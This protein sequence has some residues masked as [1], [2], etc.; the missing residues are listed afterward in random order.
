[1][2]WAKRS[3]DLQEGVLAVVHGTPQNGSMMAR[4]SLHTDTSIHMA[5]H[6]SLARLI[7]PVHR[8][9]AG[10]PTAAAAEARQ[11]L[12]VGCDLSVESPHG[13]WPV[14]SGL[15]WNPSGSFGPL[16]PKAPAHFSF[17]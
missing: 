9:A 16:K 15:Q 14:A 4:G 7:L 8:R 12:R 2:P 17:T 10:D 11:H 1:M 6:T 13:Q 3:A 5:D